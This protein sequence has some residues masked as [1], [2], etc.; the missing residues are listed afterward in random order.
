MDLNG[1]PS[2][3]LDG[4]Y[5]AAVMKLN[6]ADPEYT[7]GTGKETKRENEVS[8]FD[9]LAQALNSIGGRK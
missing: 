3:Y 7:P 8:G 4:L 1:K 5:E 9:R 6:E 2:A